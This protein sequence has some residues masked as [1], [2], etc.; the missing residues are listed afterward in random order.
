MAG[1]AESRQRWPGV[2]VCLYLLGMTLMFAHLGS[3]ITRPPPSFLLPRLLVMVAVAVL[4]WR[5]GGLPSSMRQSTSVVFEVSQHLITNLNWNYVLL[6]ITVKLH[7]KGLDKTKMFKI[8][9]IMTHSNIQIAHSYI[10]L[11]R[12]LTLLALQQLRPNCG[13]PIFCQNLVTLIT[14]F[15]DTN[16]SRRVLS[17]LGVCAYFMELGDL[18][19]KLTPTCK[20]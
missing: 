20:L 1:C 8:H 12:K 17:T 4:V 13:L 10:P 14:A 7:G 16:L 9:T 5:R 19:V 18:L 3:P 6:P 15:D 2:V 11:I